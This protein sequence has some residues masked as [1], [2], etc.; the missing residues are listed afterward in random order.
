MIAVCD[1]SHDMRGKCNTNVGIGPSSL[2]VVEKA[3]DTHIDAGKVPFPANKMVMD[4]TELVS[5]NSICLKRRF[6]MVQLRVVWSLSA[7]LAKSGASRYLQVKT[8]PQIAA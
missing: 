8:P 3:S 2:P 4:V 6:R 5:Q 7:T 1:I